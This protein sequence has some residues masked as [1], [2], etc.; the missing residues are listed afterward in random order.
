M[1]IWQIRHTLKDLWHKIG[2]SELC[3]AS[4][5]REAFGSQEWSHFTREDC[6]RGLMGTQRWLQYMT[7]RGVDQVSVK[8][9]TVQHRILSWFIRQDSWPKML[10]MCGYLTREW[11]RNGTMIKPTWKLPAVALGF[12]SFCWNDRVATQPFILWATPTLLLSVSH[13]K[14]FKF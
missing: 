6:Y 1:S 7:F 2:R 4:T 12:P 8:Y 5:K 14:Q 9:Q 3:E 11:S 10:W 13:L